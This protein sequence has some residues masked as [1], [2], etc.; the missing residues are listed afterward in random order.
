MGLLV[1]NP[2]NPCTCISATDV[3]IY[4]C[5]GSTR[6]LTANSGSVGYSHVSSEA[7]PGPVSYPYTYFQTNGLQGIAQEQLSDGSYL[8]PGNVTIHYAIRT[9]GQVYSEAF[10]SASGSGGSYSIAVP[11]WTGGGGHGLYMTYEIY[12]DTWPPIP[13]GL[14]GL[15]A[16]LRVGNVTLSSVTLQ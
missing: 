13:P 12:A 1:S 3:I 9:P 10:V 6:G 7:V 11:I 14:T 8:Y 5:T 15:G 4:H 16:D 2:N